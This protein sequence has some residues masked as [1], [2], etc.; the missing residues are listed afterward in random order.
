MAS[1]LHTQLTRYIYIYIYIYSCIENRSA[2]A[3]NNVSIALLL[4]T[5]QAIYFL[6]VLNALLDCCHITG[7]DSSCHLLLPVWIFWHILLASYHIFKTN[8]FAV[9]NFHISHF[10]C[11]ICTVLTIFCRLK[12]SRTHSK[13]NQNGDIQ[14]SLI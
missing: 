7:I 3:C 6:S 13:G 2:Y 10:V 5:V 1:F 9:I 11:F 14:E 8:S 4:C 12:I